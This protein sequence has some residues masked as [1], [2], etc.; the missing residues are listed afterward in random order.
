VFADVRRGFWVEPLP[1][2]RRRRTKEKREILFAAF[3]DDLLAER[4]RQLSDAMCAYLEWGLWHLRPVFNDWLL[5]DIDAEAVDAYRTQKV[6]EARALKAALEH[7]RPRRGETGRIMRPL[8]PSSINKTIDVLQWVLSAA[9]EYGWIETNPARGRRRR[10]RKPKL[11]P[12]YLDSVGHID[13]L[14]VAA[15]QLDADPRSR[16]GHRRALIATLVFA[17]LRSHELSALRWRDID[18]TG[19]RIQV[20]V[21]KTQA[22]LREIAL[23]PI[24]RALL[25]EHWERRDATRPD[26]LVFPTRTGGPRNKDNIRGRIL[27]PTIAR[28]NELLEDRSGVPLPKGLS[29]HKLRHTFASILVA[30]GEDPASVMYQLGHTNPAFTLRVYAHMMRRSEAGRKDLG[31]LVSGGHGPGRRR[32]LRSY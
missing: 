20:R 23:R 6:E 17:G 15:G 12:V 3:A 10:L 18:L 14:L 13:A 7:G 22:G 21:S 4:R 31:V 11:P 24:L 16:V 32:T 25:G 9:E 26:V 1:G 5:R 27:A 29:P 28:A 30:C 19:G 2:A 8:S